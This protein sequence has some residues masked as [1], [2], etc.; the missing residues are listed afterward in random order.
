MIFR[1]QFTLFQQAADELQQKPVTVSLR[2]IANSA[3]AVRHPAMQLDM[4][5]LGIGLY[6]VD[7]AG[8]ANSMQTVATLK[9][10]I[11]QLKR[12]NGESKL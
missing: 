1:K 7:S 2:H 6:G 3:A 5:R 10:S 11:A 8:P 4:I 9:S 12:A